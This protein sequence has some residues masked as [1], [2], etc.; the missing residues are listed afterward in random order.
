MWEVTNPDLAFVRLHGRNAD[1]WSANG[2]ATAS[3]RFD[4]DYS[5]DELAQLSGPIRDIS[6][7]TAKTH[8]IFNNCFEDQGQR[9]AR[10]L[11]DILGK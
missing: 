7:R 6:N 9:N 8:V 2:A 10:T 3:A 5:G 1:T 4:Y 11:M